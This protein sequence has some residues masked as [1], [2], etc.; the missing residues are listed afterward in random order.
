MLRVR[1]PSSSVPF[2]LAQL[3]LEA[4]LRGALPPEEPEILRFLGGLGWRFEQ[5]LTPVRA[6]MMADEVRRC[7]GGSARSTSS[8]VR[9]AA[10]MALQARLEH[11]VVPRMR[12]VDLDHIVRVEL[13]A[14]S[15]PALIL[16]PHAG[17]TLLLV[18]ALAARLPGLVVFGQRPADE[19]TRLRRALERNRREDEQRLPIRWETD[20]AALPGWLAEGHPVA[21]AFDDR[22][23]SSYVRI[24]FLGREALLSPDPFALGV[25]VASATIL[26]ERDKSSHVVVRA[27][28]PAD[29]RTFLAERAEPALRSAPGHYAAWLT[30]RRIAATSDDHPLFV[31]YAIDD[32]WRRWPLAS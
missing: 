28:A 26:R 5:R 1:P 9:E 14:L 8:V 12:S 31:D 32:R 3:V 20:P 4:T 10:D 18:A 7:F 30:D 22:G 24:P 11:L 25:A 15:R 19:G 13:P 29:L 27:G 16:Y 23:W 17:N 6:Q 2:D 21:A